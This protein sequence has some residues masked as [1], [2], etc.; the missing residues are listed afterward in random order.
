MAAATLRR[1]NLP[2]WSFRYDRALRRVGACFFRERYISLSRA[3]VEANDEDVVRD[4]IRHE[5]AHV[6]AWKHDRETG[7]GVVWKQWCGVTGARPRRCYEDEDV[8]LPA[9]R[10]QCTVLVSEVEWS[11]GSG[12]NQQSG[13]TRTSLEKGDVFG[14]HRLTKR[15]RAAAEIGLVSVLDTRTGERV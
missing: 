13:T 5:V 15:L 4:T 12:P 10:Y 9:A 1:H 6:L 14:R 7:H 8:V 11:R 3:F 2:E